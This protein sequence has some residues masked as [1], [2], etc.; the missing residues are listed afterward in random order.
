MSRPAKAL[1]FND[2]MLLA[3]LSGNKTQTRRVMEPQPTLVDEHG[4]WYGNNPMSLQDRPCPYGY[5]GDLINMQDAPA[6]LRLTDVRTQRLW[7]ISEEDAKAEGIEKIESYVPGTSLWKNYGYDT[8]NNW[9][10]RLCLPQNSFS[11]LWD[12]IITKAENRWE[13]NP[14]VWA[15]TFKVHYCNVDNLTVDQ[16]SG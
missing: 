10:R 5:P 8:A 3:L 12:S 9:S 11:S 6:T 4:C 16:S 1:R 7:D 15:L 2:P 13:A 14:W